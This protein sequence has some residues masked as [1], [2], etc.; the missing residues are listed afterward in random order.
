MAKH[1][2]KKEN[3]LL[4]HLEIAETKGLRNLS[5]EQIINLISSYRYVIGEL[6]RERRD[7]PGSERENYLN[8]LVCKFRDIAFSGTKV[9]WSKF[10]KFIKYDIPASTRKHLA[11][12]LI[13]IIFF[14]SGALFSYIFIKTNPDR[15]H[16]ILN[17]VLIE[18]AEHGFEDENFHKSHRMWQAKPLYVTFYV[19]N[20]TKVAFTSFALG[21]FLAI[22]TIIIL[23]YNGIAIGG[24]IAI[25]EMKGM[26]N[27]LLGFISPH[28][29]IELMAI[30]MASAAGMSLG[31][32]LLLPGRL[33]RTDALKKKAYEAISLVAGAGLL[34]AIAG[35]IET[36]VS[37]L[38]I[39]NSIKYAIGFV[40]LIL[41]M[42]YLL[43][44][45]AHSTN[46]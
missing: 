18:N 46:S 7:N 10:F 35:I 36:F 3:E 30:F 13:S 45:P 43:I 34:L 24:T 2:T 8:N 26:L 19:T 38:S 33:S 17:P 39:D 21:V 14:T 37:P 23:F 12:I 40:N 42:S 32:A 29:V 4:Q 27:N 41:F 28:G 44:R 5:D 16:Y 25:V 11:L 6:S 31:W 15:S 22:P 9:S 20:N 1:S